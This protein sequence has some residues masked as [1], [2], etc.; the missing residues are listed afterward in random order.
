LLLA[1]VSV[2]APVWADSYVCPMARQAAAQ[3]RS[4]CAKAEVAHLRATPG[5]PQVEPPC[6]CPKLTWSADAADQV[7]ELRP[8]AGPS[9]AP[10]MD[11]PRPAAIVATNSVAPRVPRRDAGP[12]S[13]P[14]LWRLNQAILC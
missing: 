10:A 11:L 4:C 9:T 12:R 2:L 5:N 8:G 7:R 14:P 3:V 13:A 1:V 6:D